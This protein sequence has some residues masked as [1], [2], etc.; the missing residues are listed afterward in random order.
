MEDTEFDNWKKIW[1]SSSRISNYICQICSFE[2][3][4]KIAA[5]DV[6]KDLFNACTIVAIF[7]YFANTSFLNYFVVST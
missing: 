6:E 2:V 1:K 3:H 7:C 4:G 5:I